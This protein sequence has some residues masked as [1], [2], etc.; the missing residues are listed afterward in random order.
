WVVWSFS[1]L[2]PG[3]TA[4]LGAEN[5]PNSTVQIYRATSK[6]PRRTGM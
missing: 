3:K 4:G 2:R 5:P 6:N 1:L